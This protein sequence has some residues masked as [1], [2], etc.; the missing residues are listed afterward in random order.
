MRELC[1]VMSQPAFLV[2]LG[3]SQDLSF[4]YVNLLDL[5]YVPICI[6][7]EANDNDNSNNNK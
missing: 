3:Y 7:N 5:S 2:Q 4:Y 1:Q 6:I